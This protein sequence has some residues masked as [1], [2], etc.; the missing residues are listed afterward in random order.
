MSHT[1]DL[2]IQF[3]NGCVI[4]C[5]RKTA[6]KRIF[7]IS[8]QRQRG[9]DSQR[10]NG[11]AEFVHSDEFYR[12]YTDVFDH[13]GGK[14]KLLVIFILL[15]GSQCVFLLLVGGRNAWFSLHMCAVPDGEGN[16]G[17][18]AWETLS[19]VD[20][21]FSLSLSLSLRCPGVLIFQATLDDC[22]NGLASGHTRAQ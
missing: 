12:T 17:F 18:R 11:K 4:S 8:P 10:G 9:K 20:S 13:L 15:P 14:E 19:A 2:R 16:E 6:A 3:E 5:F 1:V 7:C 22:L 21:P